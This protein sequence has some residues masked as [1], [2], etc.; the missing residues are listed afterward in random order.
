MGICPEEEGGEEGPTPSR[1]ANLAKHIS[2][3]ADLCAETD[4]LKDADE[5]ET[6]A[7][8]SPS[9]LWRSTYVSLARPSATFSAETG[10]A[11]TGVAL[12]GVG[13]AATGLAVFAVEVTMVVVLFGEKTCVFEHTFV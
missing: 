8:A 6:A 11:G 2:R 7:L 1:I 13:A 4:A 12:G 3:W 9:G 10:A 5:A